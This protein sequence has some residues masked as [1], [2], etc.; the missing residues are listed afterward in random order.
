MSEDELIRMEDLNCELIGV[1]PNSRC[2][3]N[4]E[5]QTLT[6]YIA[7]EDFDALVVVL[8]SIHNRIV[9]CLDEEESTDQRPLYTFMQWLVNMQWRYI[10]IHDHRRRG[11]HD[12][13]GMD[14][15]VLES[16]TLTISECGT[17]QCAPTEEE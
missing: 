16:D 11:E 6:K 2:L 3:T 10:D 13:G 14:S 7:S 1:D 15:V 5:E 12:A 9:D 17:D 4:K 8:D